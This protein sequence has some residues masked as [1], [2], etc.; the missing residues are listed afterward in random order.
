MVAYS[1]KP[2][3][4]PKIQAGTKVNTIRL[5]RKRHAYEGEMLQAYCG[6]RTKSCFKIIDDLPC[7]FSVPIRF[8]IEPESLWSIELFDG[9]MMLA[10]EHYDAFAVRDGF[11][12]MKQMARWWRSTH[13]LTTFSG[14]LIG[15]KDLP[16]EW[17]Q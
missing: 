2:S 6:M 12:D 8:A 3:F 15:W 10:P 5:P 13:E 1:Y 17:L 9:R 11:D 14:Q 16:Q 4:V 7:K